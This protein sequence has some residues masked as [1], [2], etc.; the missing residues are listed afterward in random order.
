MNESG[1][2]F[3]LQKLPVNETM[4]RFS[5]LW[6]SHQLFGSLSDHK[7]HNLCFL[8]RTHTHA[9]P[10]L[11][12]ILVGHLRQTKRLHKSKQMSII[13]VTFKM[14]V[15]ILHFVTVMQEICN[16]WKAELILER[17]REFIRMTRWTD[18]RKMK[19]RKYNAQ[20]GGS[21]FFYRDTPLFFHSKVL[22][23]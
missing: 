5:Q 16:F 14:S 10:G 19:G 13:N 12:F 11:A 23:P 15:E 18:H 4:S 17:T 3:S 21:T 1:L 8:K 2:P 6:Q 9:R 20:Y 22:F 7:L